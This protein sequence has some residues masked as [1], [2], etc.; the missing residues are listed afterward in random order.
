MLEWY[1]TAL[2]AESQ[3]KFFAVIDTL[4]LTQ[5]FRPG[6][7]RWEDV[8]GLDAQLTRIGVRIVFLHATA[9]TIW[10]CGIVPRATEQFMLEYAQ[11]RFGSTPTAV[12][13]YL[14]DEQEQ[15]QRL[16]ARTRLPHWS[17]AA[18]T[19]AEVN[20]GQAIQFWLS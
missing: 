2:H 20:L 15:M 12:R 11:T 17:L 4:H 1:V 5:C 3:I 19:D 7:L 9:D 6:I 14:V 13:D 16:L 18:E 8:A 10:H